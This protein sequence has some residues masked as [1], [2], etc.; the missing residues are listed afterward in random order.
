M[1]G[2]SEQVL[3]LGFKKAKPDDTIYFELIKAT[4]EA[5][6]RVDPDAKVLAGSF[7]PLKNQRLNGSIIISIWEF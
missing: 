5:I 6:K 2:I 7:N 1:S 3:V 4:S